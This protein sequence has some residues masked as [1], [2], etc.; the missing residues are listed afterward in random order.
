LTLIRSVSLCFALAAG[1]LCAGDYDS[2]LVAMKNAWPQFTTIAVVCDVTSS[3]TALSALTGA[4]GGMKVMVVDVKGPQDMGKAIS[5]L[6]GRKPDAILLLAGGGVAVDGSAA[7]SWLIDRG[8]AIK[9]PTAGFTGG[10]VKPGAAL[11]IGT[12]TG[13][14]L[15]SNAKVAAVAGVA[16]PAGATVL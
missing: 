13:G 12:G 7:A 14:K 15:M 11:G 9:V 6:S 4:A 10:G 1:S 2:V 3:K 8:A 16:V 5:T